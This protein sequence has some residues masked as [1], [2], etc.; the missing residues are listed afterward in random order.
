MNTANPDGTPPLLAAVQYGKVEAVKSLLAKGANVNGANRDGTTPLMIASE[1]TAY[2]PDSLPVVDI[3]IAGKANIDAQDSRG[4]T[5]LHR[6]VS[7][8]KLEAVRML[9]DHGAAID[10]K[11]SE[12]ATPL[13]YAVE[14]GKM[15][16]L[17]LLIERKA[18]VEIPN[19]S[20][21]MPLMLASEG[22][23]Y[24]PNNGPM[25]EL[26]LANGAHVDNV[27]SRGRSA[28]YRASTEGKEDAMRL[29]LDKQANPNLRANDRSTPLIEAVTYAKFAAAQLLIERGA[30]VNLAGPNEI[31]PLMIAAETSPYIKNPA[32]YLKLLLDH[33]AKKTMV[34]SQN[35]TALERATESKNTAAMELLK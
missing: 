21:D 18:Q 6:A 9:L 20:G 3:L 31:T 16:V 7:E 4:R 22:T 10:K 25:V 33:G 24:L 15:P 27:D 17:M 29:L 30:D 8:G 11:S 35:H 14:Y 5:A 19:A 13:F 2:L 12:G 23:A 1:G 32:D 34:D 28:L 26:L